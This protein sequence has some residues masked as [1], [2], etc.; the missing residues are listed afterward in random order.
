MARQC[1]LITVRRMATGADYSARI[2]LKDPANAFE[3]MARKI[4][5]VHGIGPGN[6]RLIS[7]TYIPDAVPGIYETTRARRA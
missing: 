2:W 4:R 3:A 6:L 5:L 7:A 1:Y